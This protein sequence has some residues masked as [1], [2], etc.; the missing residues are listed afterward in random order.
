MDL[1][2]SVYGFHPTY[3]LAD[4]GAKYQSNLNEIDKSERKSVGDKSKIEWPPEEEKTNNG[5]FL[6]TKLLNL[7]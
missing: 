3:T 7:I 1:N 5:K 4:K 6:I 2:N